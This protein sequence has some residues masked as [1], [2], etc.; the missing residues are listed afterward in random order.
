VKCRIG[1]RDVNVA[2]VIGLNAK[3]LIVEEAADEWFAV[4]QGHFY[5]GLG[6]G[7]TEAIDWRREIYFHG[8]TPLNGDAWSRTGDENLGFRW[9]RGDQPAL[10]G[11]FT[12][13]NDHRLGIERAIGPGHP[14]ENVGRGTLPVGSHVIDADSGEVFAVREDFVLARGIDKEQLGAGGRDGGGGSS[15]WLLR[16]QAVPLGR[17]G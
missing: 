15:G 9:G 7:R 8:G 4:D 16:F 14:E 13:M 1:A 17:R 5:D 12:S 2:L 6:Y 11:E 3:T 10:G